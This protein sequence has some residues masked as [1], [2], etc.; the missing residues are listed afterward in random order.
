MIPGRSGVA[1]RRR[2][3]HARRPRRGSALILVIV[4]TVALAALALTANLLGSA[5]TMLTKAHE[6]ERE[7]RYASE[8]ALAMG[9]SRLST[10]PSIELEDDVPTTLLSDAALKDAAG[11]TIPGVEVSVWLART[12]SKTGQHGLYASV[13]AEARD[14]RG[15]SRFV[16]RLELME[17][18]FAR[19]LDWSD[20]WAVNGYYGEGEVMNGPVWSNAD[21]GVG[22]ARFKDTVATAGR[23]KHFRSGTVFDVPPVENQPKM[24]LPTLQRLA[25]LEGYASGANLAFNAPTNGDATTAR[26]RVEFVWG[27]LA[28]DGTAI[29]DENEG[30]VRVFR[31]KKDDE[32]RA[33]YTSNKVRD[34][35]CGDWHYDN[36][37]KVRFFPVSEHDANWFRTEMKKSTA[38]DSNRVRLG[39]SGWTNNASGT[40]SIDNHSKASRETLMKAGRTSTSSKR[41]ATDLTPRCFPAGDPHLAATERTGP[42]WA[43]AEREIGG[44]STTFTPNGAKG[45]WLEWEGA[46]VPWGSFAKAPPAEMRA[47]LMPLDRS[48]NA[49]AKGVIFVEGTAALHGVLNGRVTVYATGE[50][51]FVDDLTYAV[52]PASDD[53]DD[54]LGVIAA[55]D[56]TIADNAINTPQDPDNGGDDGDTWMDDDTHF[57]LH[58]VLLA[59]GTFEPERYNKGPVDMSVCNGK[60][61]G[62]G[63]L[64]QVGGAI[65]NVRSVTYVGNPGPGLM[66][67]RDYDR[68]MSRDS[69]PYFPT[70]GRYFDNRYYEVDPL[71]FDITTYLERIGQSGS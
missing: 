40:T 13:I 32:A 27:V 64:Y 62:R 4:L 66:E 18:N 15:Q 70:T 7:F 11:V 12:G 52:N 3:R 14:T 5:S 9:R 30:F 38:R 68:R 20:R 26:L 33:D 36:T 41:V 51:T 16:R 6:R 31:A 59:L 49:G 10:D 55:K 65:V 44:D 28:G 54:M 61:I 17:E 24:T 58:G 53:C 48:L 23:I 42:G 50:L 29:G 57:T 47:Y 2:A 22:G 60:V 39:Y 71:G 35:Q 8:A 45:E 67:V 69:P 1:R 25:R 37:G 63:C 56:I 46:P 21:I 43:P 34:E 19:F